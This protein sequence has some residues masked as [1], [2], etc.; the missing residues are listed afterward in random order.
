MEEEITD[1]IGGKH[2]QYNAM[3]K[4][5]YTITVIFLILLFIMAVAGIYYYFLPEKLETLETAGPG[6]E[7][8]ENYQCPKGYICGLK[9]DPL[10]G[11]RGICIQ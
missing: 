3:K 6:N 8:Q 9:V 5:S 1:I 7:C 4:K 11:A 10:P 2:I